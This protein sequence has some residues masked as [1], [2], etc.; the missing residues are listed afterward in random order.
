MQRIKRLLELIPQVERAGLIDM[1]GG[2]FA[3]REAAG[4]YVTPQRVGEQLHW[5]LAEQDFVLFPGGGEASMARA[6]RRPCRESRLLRA[7]LAANPQWNAVWHGHPW[8]LLSYALAAQILPVPPHHAY[9]AL[10]GERPAT[11]PCAA[12]ARDEEAAVVEA[13]RRAFDKT[14]CGAVLVSGVGPFV[15]AVELDGAVAFAEALENLARAQ[16][17]RLRS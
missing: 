16:Q 2:S 8:G 13:L 4:V 10:G 12:Y 15:A 7:I 6:G 1:S 11:V 5:R 9:A 17:W 3:I 14:A